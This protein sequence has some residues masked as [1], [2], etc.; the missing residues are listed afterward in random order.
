[1]LKF[2]DCSD[3]E[4]VRNS[5]FAQGGKDEKLSAE[6]NYRKGHFKKQPTA[7]QLREERNKKSTDETKQWQWNGKR[8]G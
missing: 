1:M 8:R 5:F 6:E 3:I 4:Q 2:A 7:D